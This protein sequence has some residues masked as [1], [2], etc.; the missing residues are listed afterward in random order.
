MD[1]VRAGTSRS[2]Q[3]RGEPD[4]GN[5]DQYFD[6]FRPRPPVSLRPGSAGAGTPSDHAVSTIGNGSAK[7]GEWVS[8]LE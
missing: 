8:V 6:M 1:A 4:S 5:T 7:F 2:R 3:F